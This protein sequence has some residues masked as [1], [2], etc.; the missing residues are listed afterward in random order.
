MSDID[1]NRASHIWNHLV[2]VIGEK[3]GL[4]RA[5][6]QAVLDAECAFWNERP[7]LRDAVLDSADE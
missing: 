7:G 3:T 6:I 1:R 4:S 2:A 5:D